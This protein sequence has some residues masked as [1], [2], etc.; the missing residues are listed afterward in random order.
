MPNIFSAKRLISSK[1]LLVL[2]SP[3]R[4]YKLKPYPS[5]TIFVSTTLN[6]DEFEENFYM[7]NIGHADNANDYAASTDAGLGLRIGSR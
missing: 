6:D 5:Q 2:G 1:N 4:I 3:R 7:S